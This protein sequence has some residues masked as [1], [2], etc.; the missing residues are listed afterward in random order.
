MANNLSV[1]KLQA[2]LA[3]ATNEVTVAAA[4]INFDF[5]LVKCEAPP[6]YQPL[7][8]ALTTHR[9]VEAEGGSQHVTARRLGAL[10][11]GLCPKTPN[12]ISAFG[13]RATETSTEAVVNRP[14]NPTGNWIFSDYI[15]I[16]STSLWAA[17]TSSKAALPV[18]LLACMLAR[19]WSDAE[20]TSLWVE[21]VA[22]RRRDIAHRYQ[23]GEELPF[24]SAAA[25]TQQ[26]IT[27]DQLAK[28]DASARSWLRT[29]DAVQAKQ[30][31]QFELIAENINIAVQAET[32]PYESIIPAWIEALQSMEK[33]I[34]GEPLAV[35]NGSVLLGISAWHIYP[36][37]IVFGKGGE[38]L[39]DMNDPLVHS[40]GVMSLGLSDSRA[41]R[42]IYWSLSLS[43]HK[44]YGGPVHKTTELHQDRSRLT[45]SEFRMAV[46]GMILKKWQVPRLE[47]SVALRFLLQIVSSLPHEVGRNSDRWIEV[48]IDFIMH[49]FENEDIAESPISLGRRR[50]EFILSPANDFDRPFFG[51]TEV[52]T[53]VNNL[54]SF[55]SRIKLLRRLAPRVA[56]IGQFES[57]IAFRDNEGVWFLATVFP[58]RVEKNKERRHCR[59][60]NENC[61]W[62]P[63]WW[64]PGD[65][66]PLREQLEVSAFTKNGTI[67]T[68]HGR[69]RQD[70]DLIFLFGDADSAAVFVT[71]RG[72]TTVNLLVPPALHYD[73]ITW[74]IHLNLLLPA[75]MK[76]LAKDCGG[77]IL[78][79]LADLGLATEIYT[80]KSMEGA[81]ISSQILTAPSKIHPRSWITSEDGSTREHGVGIAPWGT[82]ALIAYFETGIF[83][84]SL[85][86]FHILGLSVGDSIYVP[87]KVRLA[88]IIL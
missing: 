11:D 14:A 81:T 35:K 16:D 4:N 87:S 73:D 54:A 62:Q 17:A 50:S 28:W 63:E 25:A 66:G 29:V 55:E 45:F 80:S 47:T 32:R 58:A 69:D 31:K 27:R 74:C 43:N 20:A 30:K 49:Y 5:A 19:L 39:I 12:L 86:E 6:E 53:L 18:Y 44:F 41:S 9:K 33:L 40:G 22:E 21:I 48:A 70:R 34:C 68:M 36:N 23:N 65:E 75:R 60:V 10:F 2:A 67:I 51:L 61:E 77:Y 85:M 57:Y 1:G 64:Q 88:L 38:K 79:F 78:E 24:A 8:Q 76:S 56:N 72:P 15:G 7:G 83:M 13:K 26:E 3:S 46:L 59:W 42:G 71:D 82:L 52:S 37:M 84:E